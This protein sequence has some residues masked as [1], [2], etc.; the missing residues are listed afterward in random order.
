MRVQ[1]PH[2]SVAGLEWPVVFVSAVEDGILPH[3][4]AEDQQEERYAPMTD[5]LG[6]AAERC[7]S[8]LC[9]DVCVLYMSL[10][11]FM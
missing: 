2:A 11:L 6:R 10:F 9:L 5:K 7:G 8:F 3:R 1:S 4:R